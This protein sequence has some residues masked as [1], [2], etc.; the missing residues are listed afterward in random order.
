MTW[1]KRRFALC[2]I[3]RYRP[4]ANMRDR[5]YTRIYCIR[6]QRSSARYQ[7][8]KAEQVAMGSRFRW[9]AVDPQKTERARRWYYK[10]MRPHYRQPRGVFLI[11]PT[12]EE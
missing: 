4:R 9:G 5:I 8:S 10:H 2:V 3:L 11:P 6:I 12:G 7:Q 1:L